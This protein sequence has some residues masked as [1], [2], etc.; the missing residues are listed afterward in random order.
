MALFVVSKLDSVQQLVSPSIG[1]GVGPAAVYQ[2]VERLVRA[3]VQSIAN[4]TFRT[5][6]FDELFRLWIPNSQLTSS[7]NID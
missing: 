2:A 7:F 6:V 4:G 1:P 5:D 3:C